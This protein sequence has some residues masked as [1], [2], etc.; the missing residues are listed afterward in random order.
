MAALHPNILQTWV[1]E[2]LP[3]SPENELENKIRSTNS[4]IFCSSANSSSSHVF[5]PTHALWFVIRFVS[6]SPHVSVITSTRA[7][8]PLCLFPSFCMATFQTRSI[9]S[10]LPSCKASVISHWNAALFS[11]WKTA[12]LL[13]A[14]ILLKS[15]TFKQQV[16]VSCNQHRVTMWMSK[17][18][19]STRFSSRTFKNTQC[20]CTP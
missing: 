15:I 12:V 4:R 5:V 11:T 8:L 16:P 19:G 10:I 14:K 20:H 7:N 1:D 18:W 13:L 17:L 6:A 2:R 3:A 9:G